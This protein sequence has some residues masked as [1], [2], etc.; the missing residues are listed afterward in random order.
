MRSARPL[1][2]CSTAR[3]HHPDRGMTCLARVKVK[4]NPASPRWQDRYV[5]SIRRCLK[6]V[7]PRLP[8]ASGYRTVY[9]HCDIGSNC[10]GDPCYEDRMRR[11]A[12]L[13]HGLCITPSCIVRPVYRMG[14]GNGSLQPVIASGE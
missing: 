9:H 10:R 2:W 14:R 1:H 5:E 12:S 3:F 11:S 7:D 4:A 8:S 6:A 13:T